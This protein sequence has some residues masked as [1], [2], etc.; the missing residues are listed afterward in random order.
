MASAIVG[1]RREPLPSA[2]DGHRLRNASVYSNQAVI[3]DKN[4]ANG[5]K[6]LGGGRL[7][8]AT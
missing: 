6:T 3:V 1:N 5:L 4:L 8:A 7:D 2:V